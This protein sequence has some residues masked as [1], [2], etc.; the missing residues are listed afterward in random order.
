MRYSVELNQLEGPLVLP[1]LLSLATICS[2]TASSRT[3]LS[4]STL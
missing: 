4:S 3:M 1:Q 2:Q